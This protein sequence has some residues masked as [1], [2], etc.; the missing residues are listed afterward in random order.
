MWE[1]DSDDEVE[2]DTTQIGRVM[3]EEG[4]VRPGQGGSGL[5]E[6]GR[7]VHPFKEGMK[8]KFNNMDDAVRKKDLKALRNSSGKKSWWRI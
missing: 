1:G 5:F 7:D 8:R 6:R 2:D 4:V 3:D